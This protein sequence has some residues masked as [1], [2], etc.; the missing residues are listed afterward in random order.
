MGISP[1]YKT[2]TPTAPVW[3]IQLV[4]DSG[5][6]N[7]SGLVVANF[8]LLLRNLDTSVETTGQGTFSNITAA[9]TVTSG[10][11]TIIISPA[12]VQY[13]HNVADV[14]IGRYRPY[15]LVTFSN[16]IEPFQLQEDWQ[17]VPL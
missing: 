17:V 7:V 15:V 9:V 11:S 4:P 5:V 8:S 6:F 16:G 10:S 3:T 13:Q 12:T 14:I 1:W 2:S